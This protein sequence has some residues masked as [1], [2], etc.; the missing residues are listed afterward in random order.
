M[1]PG[2]SGLNGLKAG[3]LLLYGDGGFLV[4]VGIA[5]PSVDLL[6]LLKESGTILGSVERQDG[7]NKYLQHEQGTVLMSYSLFDF[8]TLC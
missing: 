7:E 3:T 8:T 5:G 2:G 1:G 4:L 6:D